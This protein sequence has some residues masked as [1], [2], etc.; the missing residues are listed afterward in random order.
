[1]GF[2]DFL[3]RKSPAEKGYVPGR[4]VAIPHYPR[5]ESASN[6][7]E[8]T[9]SADSVSTMGVTVRLLQPG[10]TAEAVGSQYERIS[11][12]GVHRTTNVPDGCQRL[13]AN[14]P[15]WVRVLVKQEGH[16]HKM[17]TEIPVWVN[18]ANGK[19]DSI[20]KDKLIEELMPERDRGR[21]IYDTV[22]MTGKME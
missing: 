19:I 15:N 5:V 4:A 20:N 17:H 13:H 11:A 10:E 1:M 21:L 9:F 18:P 8:N 22:G 12:T 16:V 14:V 6:V 2:F 3:K 7:V